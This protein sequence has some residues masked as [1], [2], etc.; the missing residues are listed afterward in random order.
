MLGLPVSDEPSIQVA[1]AALTPV[2]RQYAAAKSQNPGTLLF[3]RLGDFYELFF[4]DAQ[5]ASRELQITLT[6]RDRERAVPMCGVPYH[7]AEAYISRLLRKGYRIA[8][9]E[10][11]EDPKLTKKI[12]RREVTR[13]LT[14]GHVARSGPWLRTEQLSGGIAFWTASVG[15]GAARSLDGRLSRERVLRPQ[16]HGALC[17]RGT[18]GAA[19]RTAAANGSTTD[20]RRRRFR[21][22]WNAFRR[23]PFWTIGCSRPTT[24]FRCC[25]GRWERRRWRGLGSRATPTPQSLRAHCCTMCRT[26]QKLE[27]GHIDSIRFHERAHCLQLDQVTVRNLE[28]VETLFNDGQ[29]QTTLFHT[30]DC[31]LTPMGKAPVA[32]QPG[33]AAL[34]C[35]GDS[36]AL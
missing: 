36:A 15:A 34:G 33:A 6:S 35:G 29:Q 14:P 30:L 23:A 28:L 27:L 16:R 25:S 21:R 8:I 4:E 3:F 24:R 22:R 18:E 1:E 2:M 7:A 10:Q 32:R 17:R 12:V 20:D 9:C 19:E 11:M 26:T 31:C 5:I 13:V